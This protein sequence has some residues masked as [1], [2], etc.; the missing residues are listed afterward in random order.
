M[1]CFREAEKLKKK[2]KKRLWVLPSATETPKLLRNP[3]CVIDNGF[4]SPCS[5]YY[6]CRGK[7]K[8]LERA[9]PCSKFHLYQ[10]FLHVLAQ[11]YATWPKYSNHSALCQTVPLGEGSQAGLLFGT[12]FHFSAKRPLASVKNTSSLSS[13]R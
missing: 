11:K 12:A 1:W 13:S 3:F 2:K 5:P 6:T 9:L 10:S 7:K 4:P 8:R